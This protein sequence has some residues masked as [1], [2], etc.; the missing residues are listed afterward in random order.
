MSIQKFIMSKP[1]LT[2]WFMSSMTANFWEKQGKKNAMKVFQE[3]IDRVPAYKKFLK[4]ENINPKNIQS[5]EDFKK[6]PIIDKK[7]YIKK[8]ELSD[9]ALDGRV[10]SA[11]TIETSSGYSGKPFFWLRTSKEDEL[12]PSYIGYAFTQFYKVNKISTLVI[13]SLGLGTWTAGEKMAQALRITAVKNPLMTVMTPGA[14][15][16][17][18]LRIVKELSSYY[19]QIVLNGYPPF[20]KTVIDEGE[21]RGINW[22]KLNVKLGVGGEGYTEEWREYMAQKIGLDKKDLL[23]I[24]GGYGA[25]DIGM[26]IGREYPITVVIRKL[27]LRDKDL[28]EKLFGT[29]GSLPSLLQYN[30]GA[31]YIEEVKKELIF[32]AMTGIPLVRYNI[33]DRGGVIKFADMI[34]VLKKHDYDIIKELNK[35]GFGEKDIWKLPFYY[36]FGRTDGLV[37]LFGI[38][39]YTENIHDALTHPELTKYT[40]GNFKMAQVYNKAQNQKLKLDIELKNGL[41][42]NKSLEELFQNKVIEIL[43]EKSSEYNHLYERMG[44]KINPVIVLHSFGDSEYFSR[45]SIKHKYT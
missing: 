25:A 11:Y 8:F 43:K 1:K 3:T 13:M 35:Y 6:L 2:R 24:S 39:I 29:R 27:A 38:H 23:G 44:E 20:V 9:L 22:K 5:M 32:T 7:S 26:S 14:N 12:F 34:K 17:E 37:S 30:P 33:H 41:K 16:E 45:D 28:A 36:V 40:S 10:S 4:Q 21:R 15:L 31:F 42:S 19:Q 18:V